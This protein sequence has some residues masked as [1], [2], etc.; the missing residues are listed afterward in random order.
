MAVMPGSKESALLSANDLKPL[1]T[2]D[3]KYMC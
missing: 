3:F 1:S 2:S